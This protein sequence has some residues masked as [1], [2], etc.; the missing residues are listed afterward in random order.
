MCVDPSSLGGLTLCLLTHR[1]PDASRVLFSSIQRPWGASK[2]IFE[3]IQRLQKASRV[4]YCFWLIRAPPGGFHHNVFV[5][6]TPP[7]GFQN[8]VLVDP[9]LP[10]GPRGIVFVQRLRG[11][12]QVLL[13][14][15]PNTLSRCW[16]HSPVAP[17]SPEGLQ[18]KKTKL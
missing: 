12:S 10:V 14:I 16:S 11:A 17:M 5:D 1:F 8:T 18:T 7:G 9:T 3:S 15:D 13:S 2:T 4:L 6:P